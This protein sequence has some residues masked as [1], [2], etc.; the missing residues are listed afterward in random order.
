MYSQHPQGNGAVVQMDENM[1]GRVEG[2]DW[3]NRKS[4]VYNRLVGRIACSMFR[5]RTGTN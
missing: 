2:G 3:G 4:K 1:D 5:I